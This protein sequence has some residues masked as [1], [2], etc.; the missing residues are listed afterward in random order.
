ME[1]IKLYKLLLTEDNEHETALADEIRWISKDKLLI[2][3]PYLWI[4]E[5]MTSIKEIFGE[6][7]FDDGGFNGNFQRDCICIDLKEMLQDYNL[8]FESIFPVNEYSN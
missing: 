1:E 5:F 7:M 8:N 4:N 3:V 6:G 2:W